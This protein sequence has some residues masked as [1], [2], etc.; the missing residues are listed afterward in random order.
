MPYKNQADYNARKRVCLK[1][2]A[3]VKREYL[4]AVKNRPCTDCGN[5]FPSECMDFDHRL[6]IVKKF[7]IGSA[8]YSKSLNLIVQEVAKCD[9]VCANCHR[10]RTK[11]RRETNY[12]ICI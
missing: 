11:K 4:D 2:Q 7:T 6:G 3:P 10:I 1:K 5:W 12:A 9:L 8:A